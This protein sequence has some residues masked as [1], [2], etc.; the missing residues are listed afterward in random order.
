MLAMEERP[1][2]S[3]EL[4]RRGHAE[5]AAPVAT[6]VATPS[7]EGKPHDMELAMATDAPQ[8]EGRA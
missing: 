4:L 2:K 7:R 5:V 1:P 3:V 8:L 6:P